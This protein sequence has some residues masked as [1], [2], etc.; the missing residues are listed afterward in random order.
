[1]GILQTRGFGLCAPGGVIG[2]LMCVAHVS[3]LFLASH[4]QP[5][6]D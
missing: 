2:G 5:F 3:H 6:A 1:M 4:A